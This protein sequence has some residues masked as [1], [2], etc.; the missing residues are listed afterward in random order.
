MSSPSTKGLVFRFWNLP[1]SQKREIMLNLKLITQEDLV[2]SDEEL[3][4]RGLRLAAKQGLLDALAREVDRLQ[5][6]G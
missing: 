2:L 3:Y 6:Q 1:D 5:Q 4:N